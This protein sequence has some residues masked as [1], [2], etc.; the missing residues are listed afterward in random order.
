MILPNNYFRKI[1]TSILLVAFILSAVDI[2]YAADTLT[3]SLASKP[4]AKVVKNGDSLEVVEVR[5]GKPDRDTAESSSFSYLAGL[6]AR[7]LYANTSEGDLRSRINAFLSHINF[8]R[9]GPSLVVK[10]GEGKDASLYMPYK[11]KDD[12]EL[13]FMRYFIPPPGELPYGVTRIPLEGMEIASEAIP[14]EEVPLKASKAAEASQRGPDAVPAAAATGLRKLSDLD[15]FTTPSQIFF[16]LKDEGD[17]DYADI[18]TNIL[19]SLARDFTF[20]DEDLKKI[21]LMKRRFDSF[22]NRFRPKKAFRRYFERALRKT[23]ALDTRTLK[24]KDGVHVAAVDKYIVALGWIFRE[25]GSA[26]KAEPFIRNI[27]KALFDKTYADNINFT[28]PERSYHLWNDSAVACWKDKSYLY[29]P[30]NSQFR[31]HFWESEIA[32]SQDPIAKKKIAKALNIAGWTVAKGTTLL[33][34]E[35]F[36]KLR[37][38]VTVVEIDS[39]L[40]VLFIDPA[41]NVVRPVSNGRRR[42]VLYIPRLFLADFDINDKDDM[43]ELAAYLLYLIEWNDMY[44]ALQKAKTSPEFIYTPL[45]ALTERFTKED[46]YKLVPRSRVRQRLFRLMKESLVRQATTLVPKL[47]SEYEKVNRMA[48]D[49][50]KGH[51][52]GYVYALGDYD[53]VRR[54]YMNVARGFASLGL[55]F[56]LLGIH[57][58]ARRFYVERDK[59]LRMIQRCDVG[60]LPVELQM[61]LLL[62]YLRHG[63]TDE[64]LRNLEILLRGKDFPRTPGC[65]DAE[66]EKQLSLLF[67][68]ASGN[69]KVLEHEIDYVLESLKR[70]EKDREKRRDITHVNAIAMN[71]I[72]DFK[73]RQARV[74]KDV[75]RPKNGQKPVNGQENGP[76]ERPEKQPPPGSIHTVFTLLLEE[77]GLTKSEIAE[78]LNRK[79]KTIDPDIRALADRFGLVDVFGSGKEAVYSLTAEGRQHASRLIKVFL[80]IYRRYGS[81]PTVAT[82]MLFKPEVDEILGSAYRPLKTKDAP[83]NVALAGDFVGATLKAATDTIAETRAQL[84]DE[85]DPDRIRSLNAKTDSMLIGIATSIVH[86][87]RLENM[88]CYFAG[89]I[90]SDVDREDV[91]GDVLHVMASR[92]S[93]AAKAYLK[94]LH[95][96]DDRVLKARVLS[97]AARTA[98]ENGSA[99]ADVAGVFSGALANAQ[100]APSRYAKAQALSDVILDIAACGMLTEVM[101]PIDE[102]MNQVR[103]ANPIIAAVT[104]AKLCPHIARAG[105]PIAEYMWFM[106]YPNKEEKAWD[107]DLKYAMALLKIAVA[108]S[109]IKGSEAPKGGEF[110]LDK[111]FFV[112]TSSAILYELTDMA[113]KKA[114]TGKETDALEALQ[115][116]IHC[117]ESAKALDA[118]EHTEEWI[119][120][121]EECLRNV[122]DEDLIEQAKMNIAATLFDLGMERERALR[123]FDEAVDAAS[124]P[125]KPHLGGRPHA[126]LRVIIRMAPYKE[127]R[128]QLM[129]L[130][131]TIKDD[132]MRIEARCLIAKEIMKEAG[133]PA[134]P[135]AGQNGPA[136]PY[137][138]TPP[139]YGAGRV[140]DSAAEKKA[141][142]ALSV[143][144]LAKVAQVVHDASP[145]IRD[146]ISILER[147]RSEHFITRYYI[148]G[149]FA[150]GWLKAEPSDIDIVVSLR[151]SHLPPEEHMMESLTG[152][153]DTL[154][155]RSPVKFHL[156]MLP[157]GR[158]FAVT[159]ECGITET[160]EIRSEMVL[161][162]MPDKESK[163]LIDLTE[164]GKNPAFYEP[165]FFTRLY[166]NIVAHFRG[167]PAAKPLTFSRMWQ[168]YLDGIKQ[169]RFGSSN[170]KLY[171]DLI[172]ISRDPGKWPAEFREDWEAAFVR[173]NSTLPDEGLVEK[174]LAH[175]TPAHRDMKDL[176]NIDSF[177]KG[178]AMMNDIY[179]GPMSYINSTNAERRRRGKEQLWILREWIYRR[180]DAAQKP[181]SS[182]LWQQKPDTVPAEQQVVWFNV[183]GF[184]DEKKKPA[185]DKVKS[186]LVKQ[187]FIGNSY[188]ISNAVAPHEKVRSYVAG[189]IQKQE[190]NMRR[191]VFAGHYFS[192]ISDYSGCIE[193]AIRGVCDALGTGGFNI[194]LPL[195]LIDNLVR[196]EVAVPDLLDVLGFTQLGPRNSRVYVDD[197][198]VAG[199][200]TAVAEKEAPAEVRFYT[201][202]DKMVDHIKGKKAA[203]RIEDSEEYK[204]AVRLIDTVK[205]AA[206]NAKMENRKIM[207]ALETNG[208][209]PKEQ[210]AAIQPIIT[211]IARLKEDLAKMGLDNVVF[212]R[213]EG[214]S[215]AA[216]I[217]GEAVAAGVRG[218]D[219]VILA[220]EETLKSE[221]F[222]VLRSADEEKRAFFAEIDPKNLTDLTYIRLLEMLTIAMKLAFRDTAT[223]AGH[224]DIIVESLGKRVARLIPKAESVEKDL[225]S[226]KK[227]YDTQKRALEAA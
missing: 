183:H 117:A 201:T 219:I 216:A 54:E 37:R 162:N 182:S 28:S 83:Q 94:A 207:V 153:I 98:R 82:I 212:V 8:F 179:L 39:P 9:F 136:K 24:K 89:Q 174:F 178:R 27:V 190:N 127:V 156:N 97:R 51:P 223:M 206:F 217:E 115:I 176:R 66:H 125:D 140:S 221:K 137:D 197:E 208:W 163:V 181:P 64:F 185:E 124:A 74:R 202:S 72:N 172:D 45:N 57:E 42:Q 171:S 43:N 133:D 49:L 110:I 84:K 41:R 164:I 213:G 113:G 105:L 160:G 21:D 129:A 169:G 90:L 19:D 135:Q 78:K 166:H 30:R 18:A 100:A 200:D 12:G 65:A 7:A 73:A 50:E 226:L 86:A 4:I 60:A 225:E 198:P 118:E 149:S 99:P 112:N 44:Q 195:D 88:A 47:L 130:A 114:A 224:P 209:I 222:N 93:S 67:N 62:F 132:A 69:I 85:T 122:S 101:P 26:P 165:E 191:F 13:I 103:R 192:T 1:L 25:D 75:L 22:W 180:W 134:K 32:E 193:E 138:E 3:P 123:M 63:E 188:D 194:M 144:E 158:V 91:Y 5:D 204:A 6:M 131:D 189:I 218:E 139:D 161:E 106:F 168:D 152:A 151:Q 79:E 187:G 128:Q 220:S 126:C 55:Y 210:R 23:L 159:P 29:Q 148:T 34:S 227:R 14:L 20:P 16:L 104:F 142:D 80:E 121:A 52:E 211:G 141:T 155:Q 96:I 154:N 145:Q 111:D 11:R 68:F 109:G 214:D 146:A 203:E 46:R 170:K 147:F 56:D 70:V 36:K 81:Q 199:W 143:E 196:T 173:E 116:Y 2:S 38:T 107:N 184:V 53:E 205:V 95:E 40:P 35:K 102:V 59:R 33:E 119:D 10:V 77:D 215:L 58:L 177:I 92:P 120:R 71:M 167:L 150:R 108:V 186:E 61:E 87:P 76:A 17:I 175:Y 157:F 48:A 31:K 15:F